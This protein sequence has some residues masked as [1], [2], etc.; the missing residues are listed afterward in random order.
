MEGTVTRKYPLYIRFEKRVYTVLGEITFDD[1]PFRD[2]KGYIYDGYIWIFSKKKPN[3]SKV[4]YFWYEHGKVCF[5]KMRDSVKEFFSTDKLLDLS[6]ANTVYK[7]DPKEELYDEDVLSDMNSSTSIFRPEINPEDDCLKVLI[8]MAILE[9]NINVN[10]LKSKMERSYSLSNLKTALIGKTKMSIP[11]FIIW[12]D[13]LGLGFNISIYD[14]QTDDQNPLK[15]A[16][17]YNSMKGTYEH[18]E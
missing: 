10:R 8:K 3:D 15:Y 2:G 13:L 4:P 1:Q 17:E 5:G 6:F 12:C 16:I 7:M 11:N 18:I 9:K 14:N